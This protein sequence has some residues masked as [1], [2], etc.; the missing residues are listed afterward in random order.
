M[1]YILYRRY[2]GHSLRAKIAGDIND[3]GTLV[4]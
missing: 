2:V 3:V 4:G 1:A